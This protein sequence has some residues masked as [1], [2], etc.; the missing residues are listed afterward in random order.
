MAKESSAIAG[1]G[2][3]VLREG[4]TPNS[5]GPVLALRGTNSVVVNYEDIGSKLGIVQSSGLVIADDAVHITGPA[6]RL[7]GRRELIIQNLGTGGLY[8][9]DVNV[10]AANGLMVASGDLLSLKV[11]DLGDIYGISDGASDVRI[12][13]I[14]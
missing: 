5:N 11:L 9:G 6:G 3:S 13:E 4:L 7:K 8:L 12:L 2:I 1:S 10:T 14:K